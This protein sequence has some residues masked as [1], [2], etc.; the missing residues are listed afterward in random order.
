MI[1][2][3]QNETETL[4]VANLTFENRTDRVSIYGD[5]DLTAD[6]SG[7]QNAIVLHGILSSILAELESRHGNGTLPDRIEVIAP[8]VINNPFNRAT[9]QGNFVADYLPPTSSRLV[10]KRD[11][12]SIA[13]LVPKP[14][15]LVDSREQRPFSFERFPNWIASERRT[16]LPVADYSVE[17][18]E[19]LIALERKSLSDLIITLTQ[20]RA[21]FFRMCEKLAEYRWR[22]LIIEASYEDIK[23]PYPAAHTSAHP[24]GI[25]GSVDALESKF[26]IPVLY[27][28]Q[29]KN[30]AEEKAASWLSKHHAYWFL[31]SNGLGRVLQDDDI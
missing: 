24:N 3:F 17:G 6:L 26:G 22:A 11:G 31:E 16:T 8:V 27:T 13:R 14:V 2:P 23:S 29:H 18:M 20:N 15:V 1:N 4:S 30:L 21:R 25:S 12:K 9:N 10:M 5:I 28:S 19:D 7:Y